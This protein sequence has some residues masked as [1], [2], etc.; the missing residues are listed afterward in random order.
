M[1][2]HTTAV[3]KRVSPVADIVLQS[4]SFEAFPQRLGLCLDLYSCDWCFPASMARISVNKKEVKKRLKRVEKEMPFKSA[5]PSQPRCRSMRD[6]NLLWCL[7]GLR[8]LRAP[9]V[10]RLET[11]VCKVSLFP[12]RFN[13]NKGL[14][15][16]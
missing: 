6:R 14:S 3:P 9:L 1:K 16:C 13:T 15:H 4:K 8:H 7:T 10:S 11:C 12:F 2:S 5:M